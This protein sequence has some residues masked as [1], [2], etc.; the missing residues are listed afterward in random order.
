MS[1]V[2][3]RMVPI[4]GLLYLVR[5]GSLFQYGWQYVSSFVQVL[6]NINCFG[7]CLLVLVRW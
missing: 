5:S 3:K 6:I 7:D 4:I 2:F 1:H